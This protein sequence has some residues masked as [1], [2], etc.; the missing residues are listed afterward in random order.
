[1]RPRA[2][3]PGCGNVRALI[4]KKIKSLDETAALTPNSAELDEYEGRQVLTRR[5]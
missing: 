1:M 2:G 3:R 4:S 5:G